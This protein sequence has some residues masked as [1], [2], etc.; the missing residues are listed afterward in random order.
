ML[1]KL[2][3]KLNYRQHW[4]FKIVYWLGYRNWGFSAYFEI[5]SHRVSRYEYALGVD[6]AEYPTNDL[7]GVDVLGTD[8]ASFP[9]DFAATSNYE[10]IEGFRVREPNN[11]YRKTAHIIFTPD[12]KPTDV[13]K[14][15][16]VRLDCLWNAQGCSTTRQLLPKLW[17]KGKYE[18]Q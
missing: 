9:G 3:G 10:E 17:K 6:D 8:R 14:V 7:V 11:R 2:R 5:R 12:A 4:L 15:F 18:V 1:F 16:D 13:K